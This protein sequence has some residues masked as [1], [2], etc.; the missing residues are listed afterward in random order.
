MAT[1]SHQEHQGS[2]PLSSTMQSRQ[3][4]A[5]SQSAELHGLS[6]TCGG[7]SR[8]AKSIPPSLRL[9]G[10]ACGRKSLA[11]K[12]RFQG[13][14]SPIACR[15]RMRTA[16]GFEPRQF[17]LVRM[18]WIM[19]SPE[20]KRAWVD[21]SLRLCRRLEFERPPQMRSRRRIFLG[22]R[23]LTFWGRSLSR[24]AISGEVAGRLFG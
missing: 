10:G 2:N 4:D 23:F 6:A 22:S 9:I 12:F 13:C 15:A 17:E 8:S 1:T 16:L 21:R 24:Y 18:G 14:C 19:S 3:T 11:A 7:N 20:D 5:V